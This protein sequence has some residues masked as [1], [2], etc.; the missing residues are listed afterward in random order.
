MPLVE[1]VIWLLLSP[2]DWGLDLLT[3]DDHLLIEEDVMVTGPGEQRATGAGLLPHPEW[4]LERERK[5]EREGN[6]SLL[7]SGEV[8][9]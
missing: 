5:R 3:K 1:V 9:A 6:C 7:L 4:I 2:L 8:I